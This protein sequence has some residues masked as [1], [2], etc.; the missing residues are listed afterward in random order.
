MTSELSRS[1]RLLAVPFCLVP[2]LGGSL[3]RAD[4][5]LLTV[6]GADGKV[7]RLT[8]EDMAKL[9]RQTV[10]VDKN[11]FEG[12]PLVEVA[13]LAGAP[14]GDAF[15]H[16]EHPTWHVVIEA[17]DGYKALFALPELDPAFTDKTVLLA[18]HKDG[19][20]LAAGEGPFRLVVPS[21]KR[22]ARWV[23]QVT[24]LRVGHL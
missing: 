21:D 4:E 13:R 14:L 7:V 17:K 22:R 10:Q 24:G 2:G 1:L 19:K 5:A 23:E 12:V 20:P 18:D 9:P 15:P 3:A 16:H 6:T 11:A 8:A